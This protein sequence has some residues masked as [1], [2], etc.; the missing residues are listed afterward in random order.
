[1]F[2]ALF[3]SPATSETTIP[4]WWQDSAQYGLDRGRSLAEQPYMPY[5]GPVQAGF[6][7]MQMAAIQN[8]NDAAAALGMATAQPATGTEPM[9]SIDLYDQA[10]A[11]LQQR[12]PQ[13]F[14]AYI[15]Q[16]A[17]GQPQPQQPQLAQPQ[18]SERERVLSEFQ[19][20]LANVNPFL[21][22]MMTPR[23]VEQAM[24]L[25]TGSDPAGANTT[26][27]SRLPATGGA[28]PTP[29]PAQGGQAPGFFADLFD[30][31]G[32]GASGGPY[33][34]AGLLS[35]AANMATGQQPQGDGLLS[36]AGRA[37]FGGR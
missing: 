30:G 17:G 27:G 16:F 2:N 4:D 35:A 19:R 14:G 23:R 6:D 29:Q 24:G 32:L 22:A 36:R 37:I 28:Q 1:M 34:G 31:G 15:G 18:M 12:M 26:T 25:N 10:L 9:S 7:P 11:S 3:G 13:A 33:Q 21:G 8:N 20:D 5:T